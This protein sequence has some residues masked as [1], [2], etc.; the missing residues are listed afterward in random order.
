[1]INMSLGRDGPPALVIGDAMRYA[2]SKGVFIAVSA[3]ND[4]ENGNPVEALA[5]Q[6][7]PIDGAMVVAAVGQDQ[8]RAYYSGVHSYVEIAAPGGNVRVGGTAGTILQQTYDATF[9]NTYP[10]ARY[11][12]PRFDVFAYRY[13]Q[14][15][16]MA[17]PHVAGLAALLYS[18]GITKPAAIE[19]ALKRFATDLGAA[20]R[21]EEYGSGLINPRT[22]LRG[23][24]LLK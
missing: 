3:G 23:L 11:A 24:G 6:A 9:A 20:G 19:A 21:D 15:T 10:P 18:Q 2:V 1:V 22:T 7:G 5:Q 13:S 12:A 8:R 14:G 4:Y 17:T 16:S